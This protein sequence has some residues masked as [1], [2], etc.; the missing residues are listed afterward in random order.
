VPSGWNDRVSSFQGYNNCQIKL[1]TNGNMSGTSW[2]PASY[3]DT[4]GA[5]NNQSSSMTFY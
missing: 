1:W 4:V 5:L 3:A 2:G